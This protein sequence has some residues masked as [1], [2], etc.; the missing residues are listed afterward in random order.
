MT[1][2]VVEELQQGESTAFHG[3]QESGSE[4]AAYE[5]DRTQADPERRRVGDVEQQTDSD[6]EGGE[7]E[8]G[9]RRTRK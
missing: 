7:P 6:Q 9:R 1:D 5:G 8:D 4:E 2:D 3:L